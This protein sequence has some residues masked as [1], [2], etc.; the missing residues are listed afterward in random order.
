M[1]APGPVHGLPWKSRLVVA[2]NSMANGKRMKTQYYQTCSTL[3]HHHGILLRLRARRRQLTH[4]RRQLTHRRPRLIHPT[5]LLTYPRHLAQQ[6]L[7][8]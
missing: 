8:P 1:P 3:R 2:W 6:Q 4:R 7:L 5:L